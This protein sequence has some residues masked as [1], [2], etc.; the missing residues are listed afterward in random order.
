MNFKLKNKNDITLHTKNK[1]C[2]ED[3]S[4]GIDDAEKNKIIPENIAEG[5]S[6]LGVTGTFR[7]GID[8]SDATATSDDLLAGKI[9]Y[10]NEQKLVGTIETYDYT[11]TGEY[12]RELDDFINGTMKEY[13]NDKMTSLPAYAFCGKLLE[14]IS[15]PNV[16]TAGMC[17]FAQCS[18]LTEINLPNLEKI[19]AINAFQSCTALEYIYLPK[20]QGIPTQC[21]N[22]CTS[23]KTVILDSV[24][25]IAGFGFQGCTKMEKL[26]IR[27]SKS[28]CT[29]GNAFYGFTFTGTIYVP[30]SLVEQYCNHT[31]WAAY[32]EQIKP[33]SELEVE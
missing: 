28:I 5:Q 33:L 22:G 12:I 26:I 2:R 9:A 10:A 25:S 7:G 17:A 3:I 15:L 4:V 1:Y 32:A 14:K 11:T 29:L 30:D 24:V 13:S 18:S 8:T 16:T 31:N 23:L 19:T 21:F 20:L 27:Q 6:I